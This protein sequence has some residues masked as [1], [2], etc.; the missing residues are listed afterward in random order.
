LPKLPEV[1]M[2]L[3]G[4]RMDESF[5]CKTPMPLTHRLHEQCS[6]SPTPVLSLDEH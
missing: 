1:I 2:F 6:I 5:D 4:D 3:W